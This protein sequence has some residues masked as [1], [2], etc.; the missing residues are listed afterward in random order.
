MDKV[1]D[2]LL[3]LIHIASKK[4][5]QYLSRHFC[6]ETNLWLIVSVTLTHLL[7]DPYVA[8]FQWGSGQDEA[9]CKLLCYA[10]HETQ[11]TD[12]AWSVRDLE[13]GYLSLPPAP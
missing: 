11:Q 6:I 10:E 9:L 2:K 7:S 8:S 3:H 4:K 1:K 13:R 5:A 12:D